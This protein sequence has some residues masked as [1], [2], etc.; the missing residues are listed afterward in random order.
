M[1]DIE[2]LSNLNLEI[3]IILQKKLLCWKVLEKTLFIKLFLI[4]F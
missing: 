3:Q 4:L 2:K 1:I